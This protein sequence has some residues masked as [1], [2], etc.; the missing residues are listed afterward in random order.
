MASTEEVHTKPAA[1][2]A[3]SIEEVTEVEESSPKEI[4]QVSATEEA[5]PPAPRGTS[6]LVREPEPDA[7]PASASHAPLPL[8]APSDASPEP[9]NRTTTVEVNGQAIALDHLG[10]TVINRDGTLSRIAN[11]PEM[12]PWER[13]NTLKVLGKRNQLRLAGLRAEKGINEKEIKAEGESS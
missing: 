3:A 13:E 7:T 12:T 9:E 6:F 2:H 5:V 8:P 1:P 10:P 4:S 11:W